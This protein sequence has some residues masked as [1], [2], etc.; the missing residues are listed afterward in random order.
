MLN[1][2]TEGG[3]AKLDRMIVAGRN[4]L[5]NEHNQLLLTAKDRDRHECAGVS[6]FFTV[7]QSH[8]GP[9]NPSEGAL[10]EMARTFTPTGTPPQS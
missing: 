3:R 5:T 8:Q 6:E 7:S 2:E 10:L 9:A 4:G 1:P